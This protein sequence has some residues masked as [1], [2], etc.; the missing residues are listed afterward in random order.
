MD[1]LCVDLLAYIVQFLDDAAYVQFRRI[2][3]KYHKTLSSELLLR[4]LF[5][6]REVSGLSLPDLRR[7]LF[8]IIAGP[9]TTY[10]GETRLVNHYQRVSNY[11][12]INIFQR[13]CFLEEDRI[14]RTQWIVHNSRVEFN[15]D[16]GY[17]FL[18]P[19]HELIIVDDIKF[20]ERDRIPEV[21]DFFAQGVL[22]LVNEDNSMHLYR[23]NKKPI[24]IRYNRRDVKNIRFEVYSDTMYRLKFI[25]YRDGRLSVA[26]NVIAEDVDQCTYLPGDD[27]WYLTSKG[28]LYCCHCESQTCHRIA[29][30]VSS[31][32]YTRGCTSSIMYII[33]YL[34]KDGEHWVTAGYGNAIIH[35]DV[36]MLIKAS[37]FDVGYY[38]KDENLLVTDRTITFD[39]NDIEE[40]SVVCNNKVHCVI[41]RHA[42]LL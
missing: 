31:Y 4:T 37:V 3:K 11:L 42:P 22:I 13:L 24:R 29:D 20:H 5:R 18:T 35:N 25:H 15:P 21:Y 34:T 36:S 30:N 10:V 32:T 1:T 12:I 41:V 33:H 26:G 27:L 8:N 14:C 16:Y 19:E 6:N 39:R 9:T 23:K 17:I 2:N 40:I 7:G 28:L 38:K